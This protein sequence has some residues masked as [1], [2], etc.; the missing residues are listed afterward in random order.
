MNL[1][2]NLTSAL[3]EREDVKA[4]KLSLKGTFPI[5]LFDLLNLE[6]VYLE[7]ECENFP[8]KIKGWDKLKSLGKY[9]DSAI[10]EE[11]TLIIIY[12]LTIGLSI[13]W[14]IFVSP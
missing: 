3:K 14:S 13:A 1:Y 7:G 2:K 4:I 8:D 10:T 5:E 11:H 9:I 12:L 6:E